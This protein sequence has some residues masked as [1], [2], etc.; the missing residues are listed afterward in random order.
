MK[1]KQW[2][3]HYPGMIYAKNL[4]FVE[5]KTEQEARA[6]LRAVLECNKLPN[7]TSFWKTNVILNK[8]MKHA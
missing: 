5:P 7:G 3:F 6:Y 8:A 4:V 1:S 2:T